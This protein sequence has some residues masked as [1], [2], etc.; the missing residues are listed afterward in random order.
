[1]RCSARV[2]SAAAVAGAAVGV[3]APPASADP[4]ADITP[5]A[6][7]PGGTVIVS[8]ACDAAAGTLPDFIEASSPGFEEGRVRL[9]RLE[10]F[11]GRDEGK[12]G[13]LYS[14]TARTPVAGSADSGSHPIA[15]QPEWAVDGR[16]PVAPDGRE[17]PWSA[18]F[19][20]C[21][22]G[23]G[24]QG[25]GDGR[26]PG[27]QLGDGDGRVSG[28][29]QGDGDGRQSGRQQ[30]DGRAQLPVEVPGT[31]PG[32]QLGDGDGRVSGRLQGE[33]QV[34]VPGESPTRLPGDDGGRQ[35]GQ[36]LGE[37]QGRQ[38]GQDQG[39]GVQQGQGRNE[40]Q[41]RQ[42]G[43]GLG[44]GQGRQQGQGQGQG[45]QQG[46]GRNEGQG[47]QDGERQSGTRPPVGAQHGVQAGEGGAFKGSVPA[48]ATGGTLIAGAL[49]AAV[50]R[51]W[52]RRP[53]GCG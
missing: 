31:L 50:H 10:D 47:K 36:G 18:W 40:G 25:E 34:Q 20:V 29:L 17:K 35:Q 4:S 44:E 38:Q 49:G 21:H 32:G 2:L 42:Q 46:Q 24:R 12:A 41:G 43:Q 6:V 14:G 9:R 16:C 30:G 15:R 8:V 7:A 37:G 51:V 27:H 22:D 33:G 39:Q 3:L 1:M 23:T 28:R 5:R 48:L 45:V 11:G 13:V 26:Q 52:R 53:S 19:S